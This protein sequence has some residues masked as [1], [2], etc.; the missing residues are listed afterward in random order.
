VLAKEKRIEELS[1][2]IYTLLEGLR[3]ISLSIYPFMPATSKSIMSQLGI[4]EDPSSM[5]FSDVK[6]W[7]KLKE[8]TKVNKSAPLFPRIEK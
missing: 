1:S 7:G 6:L 5:E 8:G 4:G 3:I 2:L